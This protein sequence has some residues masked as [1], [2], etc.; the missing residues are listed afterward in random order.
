MEKIVV[1]GKGGHA[2]SVIDVIERQG[3][4]KV[5]GY[6]V[7]DCNIQ[8]DNNYPIIGKDQDLKKIYQAGIQYAVVGIGFLGKSRLR[9]HLYDVLKEIGFKLPVICDPSAIVSQKVEI[10]EGTFIGKGTIINAGA[11]IDRMCII[12]TGAIVEH[13]CKIGEFS[14]ISVGAVLCGEV[15]IGEN[16]LVGANATVIQGKR[17]GNDSIIGAGEVLKKNLP[18]NKVYNKNQEK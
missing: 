9:N 3:I 4:Y 6:I 7:N 12:N 11:K 2:K 5:A 18:D 8:E 10:G 15:N 1:I 13:D 17:V 14:H 16:V